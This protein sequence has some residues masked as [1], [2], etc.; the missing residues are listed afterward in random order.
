MRRSSTGEITMRGILVLIVAFVASASTSARAVAI[1]HT[2]TF[3]SGT[4]QNWVAGGG[5]LLQNPPVPPHVLLSGGPAGASDPFLV[6]TS[7][8]GAGPG[9]RLTAFNILAQW[10]DNYL[11]NGVSAIEMDLRNLGPTVLTIRLEFEN[12]FGGGDRAVTNF[13][14][15]LA[16]GSDWTHA[17]F[18][19][20]LNELTPLS[21]T[22]ADALANTT[23]LR[24]LHASG[25][26]DPQP[27]A[28]VLG[29]DNIAA[30]GNIA[31]VSEPATIWIA[32]TAL[33]FFTLLRSR[34]MSRRYPATQGR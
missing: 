1:G 27:I 9:S 3:Q 34:A 25:P 32:L 20:S 28:G 19:V 7:S 10:A 31:A 2:D 4:T 22:V 16:P 30:T 23:V 15:T 14:M 17:L 12:P 26:T 13:G 8:G 33:M 6:L 29:I 11:T 5:P 21:G 18:P 24:I